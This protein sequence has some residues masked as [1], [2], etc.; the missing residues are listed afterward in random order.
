MHLVSKFLDP[1]VRVSE[2]G[3]CF[4]SI[5]VD[6]GDKELVELEHACTADTVAPQ[7]RV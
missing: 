4:T 2:Q 3:L 1:F 5:K 6:G 7:D